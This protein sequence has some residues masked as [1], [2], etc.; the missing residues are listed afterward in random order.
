MD[1]TIDSTIEFVFMD[2]EEFLEP[3]ER[4]GFIISETER[5]AIRDSVVVE[6]RDK[7]FVHAAAGD[8][9]FGTTGYGPGE[10]MSLVQ[11]KPT[12]MSQWGRT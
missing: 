10:V 4:V 6:Y 1:M 9:Q 7:L 3:R 11:I 8:P 12:P 5:V 2:E